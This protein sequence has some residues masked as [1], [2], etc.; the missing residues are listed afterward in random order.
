VVCPWHAWAFSV[1]TGQAEYPVHERVSVFP[2]RVEGDEV[3]VEVE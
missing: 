2:L 3:L 1:K